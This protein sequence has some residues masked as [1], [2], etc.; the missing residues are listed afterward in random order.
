MI[1]TNPLLKSLKLD[2]FVVPRPICAGNIDR[3]FPVR[4]RRARVKP[5]AKP[6]HTLRKSCIDDW[7]KIGYPPSVVQAW[8]GHKN[9][10]TTMMY[11]SKVDKRDVKRATTEM[12]LPRN[13]AICDAIG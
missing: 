12:F 13:D 8:A 1:A 7:A 9:I 11:Y 4:C 10:K 6:L 3:G 5:L 2:A